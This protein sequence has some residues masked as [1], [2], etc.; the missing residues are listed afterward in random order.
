M[1]DELSAMAEQCE[2]LIREGRFAEL[3]AALPAFAAL[4]AR[5]LAARHLGAFYRAVGLAMARRDYPAA[6][7]LLQAL[8]AAEAVDP[9]LRARARNF[10]AMVPEFQG[11]YSA[12]LRAYQEALDACAAD[13]PAGQA[14]ALFN[15][16]IVWGNYLRRPEQALAL[17]DRAEALLEQAGRPQ[18]MVRLLNERGVALLRL[19]R[20][21]EARAAL[22]ASLALCREQGNA[23]FEAICATNLGSWERL[24]GHW[25]EAERWYAPLPAFFAAA[26]NPL[27]Q[28]EVLFYRAEVAQ[29]QRQPEQAR[30]FLET[31]L[32]L[33]EA[34]ASPHFAALAHL[35]LARLAALAE[36]P[37][38]ALDRYWRAAR[39][40]EQVRS[41]QAATDVRLDFQAE[42][43]ALYR[44][45]AACALQ[46][47][48]VEDALLLSEHARARLLLETLGTPP[49]ETRPGAPAGLL[50]KLEPLEAAL[51]R[52]YARMFTGSLGPE[53]Q[54]ELARQETRIAQIRSTL[55][56]Y[57][58]ETLPY[59]PPP[60]LAKIQSHLEAGALVLSY[61]AVADSLVAL[62]VDR[63]QVRYTR[64]PVTLA[65]VQARLNEAGQLRDI[66][67]DH[68]T[69]Y[70]SSSLRVLN[71][72]YTGL[73]AP[74][75][76]WLDGYARV[77]LVPDPVLRH[78]PFHLLSPAPDQPA[79]LAAPGCRLTYLPGASILTRLPGLAP[80]APAVVVGYNGAGLVLVE[81]H[82]RRV[83]E[84]IGGLL[85][86][87]PAAARRSVR[88]SLNGA[89]VVYLA[90]HN[91]FRLPAPSDS[92][93][94]LA[95]D[96][97]LTLADIQRAPLRGSRVVLG[98]CESSRTAEHGGDWL[99]LSSACLQAGAAQVLGTLWPVNE[100]ATCLL[101]D[102]FWARLAR[103]HDPWQAL[104]QAQEE[105]RTLTLADI[106]Q[107][108]QGYELPAP[109]WDEVEKRLAALEAALRHNEH[110]L[111]HP[112]YW[113]PFV[114][115]GR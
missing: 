104:G 53:E 82:T 67:P 108:L 14:R 44:E 95:Q 30:T 100:V 1:C 6:Q 63:E 99:G 72:L 2:P 87:G 20:W 65:Q 68:R 11:H 66:V 64:L 8:L 60:P 38:P 101:M 29:A 34:N 90:G 47:G 35:G 23:Y 76:G 15:Q 70:L 33:A 27:L 114:W 43:N 59:Q 16:A 89:A 28:A 13:D 9:A 115:L 97:L 36:G 37:L 81:A 78:L 61:F 41:L 51:H 46:A 32:Q 26:G 12:A 48:R 22:E 73:L 17:L 25:V 52:A 21:P 84:Q 102:R 69:G 110:P 83:A 58:Q 7:D 79:P 113:A 3:L 74:V 91:V 94:L 62:G 80:Q 105:I 10:A 39:Q 55:H 103:G 96:E 88:Q 5:N 92:G 93:F 57:D 18:E 71:L 109:A 85:L 42:W 111:D 4:L 77:H 40:V 56:R 54:A 19:E 31:V 106:R 98:G 50:A 86:C 107:S 112:Y 49:P 75:A 45:A 24:Q